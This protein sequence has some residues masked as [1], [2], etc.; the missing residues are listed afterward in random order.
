MFAANVAANPEIADRI[1]V[2]PRAAHATPGVVSMGSRTRPGDSMSTVA[3]HPCVI[4]WPVEAITPAELA[5]FL[6]RDRPA[7]VKADIERG[8][9]ALV[10]AAGAIWRHPSI[11]LLRSVHPELFDAVD[12][13][14]LAWRGLR[15]VRSALADFACEPVDA[16]VLVFTRP[17]RARSRASRAP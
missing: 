6:P 2:I 13:A 12:A 4:A 3:L 15:R 1:L 14:S 11:T 17:R 8:E 10:P 5:A 7:F 16:R 9:Y